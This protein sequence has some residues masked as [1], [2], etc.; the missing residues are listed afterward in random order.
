MLEA[1]I[2]DVW[3]TIRASDFQFIKEVRDAT[4]EKKDGKKSCVC[5]GG[6]KTICW[7]GSKQTIRIEELSDY[8][9]RV[10]YSLVTST[11]TVKYT[12]KVDT[13]HLQR[14][15]YPE[16]CTFISWTTDFSS[17]ANLQVVSDNK[18]KKH[19]AFGELIKAFKKDG[20]KK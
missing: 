5:V 10:V 19:D 12:S 9:H 18:F 17:D 14:I 6:S 3:K 20:S 16:A 4:P 13:I 2:G 8:N 11:H 1:P 15:T 7:K